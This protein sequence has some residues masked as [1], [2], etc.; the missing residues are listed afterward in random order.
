MTRLEISGRTVV[1][2]E[3]IFE[4][5]GRVRQIISGPDGL[6]YLLLQNPTGR[7]TTIPVFGAAPGMVIRLRPVN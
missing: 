1:A 3:T 5:F 2:Q 7:G 6:F 4:Q